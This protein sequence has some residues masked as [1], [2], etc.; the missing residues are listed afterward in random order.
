VN[1]KNTLKSSVAAAALFAVA[2]PVTSEAGNITN[3][4]TAKLAISGQVVK[5]V[6]NL[7]DGSSNKTFLT[8]GGQTSSRIR[9]VASAK[10][11]DSVTVGGA[12]E[13]NTPQSDQAGLMRLGAPGGNGAVTDNKSAWAMRHNYLYASSK[14]MGKLTL[15]MTSTAA[16]GSSEASFTGTG[17]FAGSAGISA[18]QDTRFIDSSTSSALTESAHS[19]DK[20]ISNLDHTGRADVIRYDAPA[21]MGLKLKTS[22]QHD[23]NWDVA[24]EYADKVEGVKLKMRAGYT[25]M[26]GNATKNHIATGSIALGLDSGFHVALAGGHENIGNVND[27]DDLIAANVSPDTNNDGINDP[28]FYAVTVGYN[29]KM[30]AP[31]TTAF[32]INYNE[33][34]NKVYVANQD[35]NKGTSL[36]FQAV[37][38]F[39]SIGSAIGVEWAHYTYDSET[40]AG[41]ANTY[42][43]IDAVTLSTVFKF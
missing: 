2:A 40:G 24:A 42:D 37:Q 26:A 43:D 35:D 31:G 10:L 34:K 39:S 12:I 3:G 30:F 19:V 1:L 23:G 28:H 27:G 33:T 21:I 7:D 18:G 20:V 4:K 6:T 14:E 16:D 29:A 5:Q 41:V 17:I 8:D 15:G 13:M 11:S 9:W 32:A 38:N 25:G 22:W 36:Q